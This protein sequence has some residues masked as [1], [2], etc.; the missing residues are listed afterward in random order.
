MTLG[1][2]DLRWIYD[3]QCVITQKGYDSLVLMKNKLSES[4]DLH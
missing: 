2:V 1:I 4:G 3:D